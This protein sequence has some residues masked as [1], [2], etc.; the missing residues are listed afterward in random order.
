MRLSLSD[1]RYAFELGW[2]RSAAGMTLIAWLLLMIAIPIANWT[3]GLPLVRTLIVVSVFLQALVAFLILLPAWGMMRTTMT[4]VVTGVLTLLIEI[5]GSRTGLLFGAYHYTDFLQPQ[6][7]GV[8]ILIPFAWFMMLPPAW[9]IADRFRGNRFLFVLVA[10][11]AMTAW[12]LFLDPQMVSWD[13]WVWA[14]PGGYFGIPWHNYLGWLGTA[15]LLTWLLNPPPLPMGPLVTVYGITWF[16]STFGL[17]F[18]WGLAGPAVVG[19]IV[20]GAFLFLALY[21]PA[22]AAVV[23]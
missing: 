3:F 15:M 16:L 5:V 20:M 6:I 19:G 14:E 13:L 8:P 12:D 22:P 18:F 9:A 11:L 10:G 21:R 2:L 17:L 1:V 7:G 4:L 23:D